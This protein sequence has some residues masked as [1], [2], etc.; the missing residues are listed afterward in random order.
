MSKLGRSARDLF[1]YVATFVGVAGVVIGVAGNDLPGLFAG[2]PESTL[3]T[4]RGKN[5]LL[6][7]VAIRDACS[8]LSVNSAGGIGANGC[9]WDASSFVPCGYCANEQFT[10]MAVTQGTTRVNTNQHQCGGP[11]VVGICS[12]DPVN[13]QYYCD[14]APPNGVQDG[15]CKGAV[16][17]SVRQ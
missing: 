5:N 4:A 10:F 9:L 7:T 12:Y 14:V 11:R 13:F 2:L 1:G 3:A 16:S 17:D 6:R 15:V 8:D